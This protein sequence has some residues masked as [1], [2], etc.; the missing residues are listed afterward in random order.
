MRS[1]RVRL[2]ASRLAWWRKGAHIR[3]LIDADDIAEDE[4][5][6]AVDEYEDAT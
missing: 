4:L 3:M 2:A 5:D 6:R 1:L